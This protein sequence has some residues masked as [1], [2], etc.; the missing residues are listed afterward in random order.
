MQVDLPCTY[1]GA[2]FSRVN[3]YAAHGQ[4]A[5]TMWR[6]IARACM[7]HAARCGMDFFPRLSDVRQP[8]GGAAAGS[9]S[10]IR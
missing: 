7:V 6:S 5:Q 10:S 8:G 3:R 9:L 4:G 2:H 1:C